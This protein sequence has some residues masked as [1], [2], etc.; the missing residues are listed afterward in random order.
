MR[1]ISLFLNKAGSSLKYALKVNV[2][3]KDM[4]L[5]SLVNQAYQ[6]FFPDGFPARTCVEVVSLP[7]PD[8]LV[9]I[10]CI[11]VKASFKEE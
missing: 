11:A 8:A 4:R 3:L 5:F 9:E 2:F 10:D 6:E 7:D 1:N